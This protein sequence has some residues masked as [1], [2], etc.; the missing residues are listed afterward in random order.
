MTF[1]DAVAVYLDCLEDWE[2]NNCIRNTDA[3]I[4]IME[5]KGDIQKDQAMNIQQK[6]EVCPPL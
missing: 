3:C 4:E 5:I 6:R 2:G 1:A